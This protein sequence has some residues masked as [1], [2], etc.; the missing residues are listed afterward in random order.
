MTCDVLRV[1]CD[2]LRVVSAACWL[3]REQ[4]AVG[5]YIVYTI[6]MHIASASDATKRTEIQ[7]CYGTIEH[8]DIT[9]YRFD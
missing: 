6:Y 8:A 4:F 1:T 5:V 7:D 3:E 2:V 9:L